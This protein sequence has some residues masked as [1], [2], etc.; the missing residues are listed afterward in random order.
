MTCWFTVYDI[1]SDYT[2]TSIIDGNFKIF[3]TLIWTCLGFYAH[4]LSYRYVSH[5]SI[6]HYS[7]YFLIIVRVEIM[8]FI[9]SFDFYNLIFFSSRLFC[10]PHFVKLIKLHSKTLFK[11]NAAVLLFLLM[12]LFI[13]V[14]NINGYRSFENDICHTGEIF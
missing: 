6:N 9:A 2:K 14:N 12:S 4:K 10:H 7:F 1:I 8:S 5:I 11:M 13:I 3:Y